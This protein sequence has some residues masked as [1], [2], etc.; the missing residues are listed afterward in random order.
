MRRVIALLLVLGLG[1]ASLPV[2]ASQSVGAALG[3]SDACSK[4]T[5]DAVSLNDGHPRTGLA[6]VWVVLFGHVQD[7]TSGYLNQQPPDPNREP[8]TWTRPPVNCAHTR[9]V[10]DPASI[11]FDNCVF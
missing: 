8:D 7:R 1:L 4:K 11:E 5:C 3:A 9:G 2:G 6:P 10:P